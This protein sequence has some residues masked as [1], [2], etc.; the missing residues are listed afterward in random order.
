MAG[1]ITCYRDS[2]ID[3]YLS[4]R[5][6]FKIS[7]E[8]TGTELNGK[9]LYERCLEQEEKALLVYHRFGEELNRC[10]CPFLDAFHPD[11]VV[12]GG[13]SQKAFPISGKPLKKNV[14]NGTRRSAWNRRPRPEPCRDC[15]LP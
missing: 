3:D 11:C 2:I 4:V 15:L 10:I 6:L 14:K 9:E 12:L 7:R 13:R 5:G 8:I 1:S